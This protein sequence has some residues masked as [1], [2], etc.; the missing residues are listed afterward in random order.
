MTVHDVLTSFPGL[1][2]EATLIEHEETA[3][4]ID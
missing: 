3:K 2:Y 4:R 1:G